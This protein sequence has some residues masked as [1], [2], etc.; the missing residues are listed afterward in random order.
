MRYLMLRSFFL[1]VMALQITLSAA[2]LTPE[3]ALKRLLE[4]NKHFAADQLTCPERNSERRAAIVSKQ[5]P[6]AIILGCA[7]S[8]VPPELVFDQG[9]GDLFI[10][11]VAGNV[12]GPLEQNS[13]DYSVATHNPKVILVLGHENCGAVE[14]VLKGKAKGFEPL[15]TLI[16]PAVQEARKLKDHQ[17]E[18]AIKIN[19]KRMVDYLKSTPLIA[20]QLA[21]KKLIV[22]GGYYELNSGEVKIL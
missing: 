6:F 16:E 17:L 22:V 19:V 20:K 11:R 5:D 10:V 12:V 9:V 15:L 18:Q 2:E 7:D 13:I 21:D 4:G 1:T 14:A 3:D 8:R